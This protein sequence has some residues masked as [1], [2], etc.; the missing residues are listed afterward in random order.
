M[1]N[2]TVEAPPVLRTAESISVRTA[3][4][5]AGVSLLVMAVL[6]GATQFMVLERL[7]TPEDAAQTA[8]DILGSAGMFR[9]GVAS[10]FLVI[11]L[12]VVVAWALYSVFAP[13]N[14][15]I[16]MLAAW[17]R[18][19]YSAIFM[20]AISQLTGILPL[21]ENDRSPVFDT[22]QSQAQ[23]LLEFA[24][25]KNIW[26]AGLIL[27]GV[28]LL[29]IGYLAVRAGYVPRWLGGLIV[30]GGFGY[31][32]DS[33][34]AVL[35]SSIEISVVTFIGELVLAFWLVI[36]GRRIPLTVHEQRA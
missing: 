13:V 1:T 9:L 33:F 30:L 11:V 10:L 5:V 7:V 32:F 35:G 31:A 34:A 4:V 22:D 29:L 8:K 2:S 15:A 12:D 28:H 18:L 20:V 16:S 36:R 27:F 3:S 14:K 6:A 24:T 17:F 21:L 26:D 25:F 19:A 23:A